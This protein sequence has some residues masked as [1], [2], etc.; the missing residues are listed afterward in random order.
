M[1]KVD[2]REMTSTINFAQSIVNKM[3]RHE[4]NIAGA[5]IVVKKGTPMHGQLIDSLPSPEALQHGKDALI[6]VKASQYLASK[7]CIR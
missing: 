4:S 1:P 6:A 7:H 5:N 3:D 2:H